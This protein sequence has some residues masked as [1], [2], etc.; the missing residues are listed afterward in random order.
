MSW[1]EEAKSCAHADEPGEQPQSLRVH[2]TPGAGSPGSQW[3]G[4]VTGM[5]VCMYI[6]ELVV[7]V[8]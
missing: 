1:P 6:C 3:Q 8:C 2:H 5:Y 7:R 4:S